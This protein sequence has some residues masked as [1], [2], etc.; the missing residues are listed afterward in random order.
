MLDPNTCRLQIWRYV[1]HPPRNAES[2]TKIMY[3]RWTHG[4]NLLANT[5]GLFFHDT[6]NHNQA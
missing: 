3:P 2:E 4:S 1:H 6:E 5:G